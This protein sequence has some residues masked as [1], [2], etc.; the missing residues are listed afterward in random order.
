MNET[1]LWVDCVFV[2]ATLHRGSPRGSRLFKFAALGP[3]LSVHFRQ[4]NLRF[5]LSYFGRQCRPSNLVQ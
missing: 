4:F 2:W 1:H 5:T 3:S